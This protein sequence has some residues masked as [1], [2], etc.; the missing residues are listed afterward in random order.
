MRI[1]QIKN[2]ERLDPN[3]SRA[4]VA[5]KKPDDEVTFSLIAGRVT[6]NDVRRL[7]ELGCKVTFL[8]DFSYPVS[9]R[10]RLDLIPEVL[11]EQFVQEARVAEVSFRE[12]H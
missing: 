9:C 10:A 1:N 6:D 8:L 11:T 5:H 2:I 7:N 4:Y 3:V 12:N